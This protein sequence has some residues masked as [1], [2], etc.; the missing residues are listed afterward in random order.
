MD[1]NFNNERRNYKYTTYS[2]MN[3]VYGYKIRSYFAYVCVM[4]VITPDWICDPLN[5]FTYLLRKKV[6]LCKFKAQ[7]VLNTSKCLQNF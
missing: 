7:K 3:F 2:Y 1:I 4:L 6:N 5:L